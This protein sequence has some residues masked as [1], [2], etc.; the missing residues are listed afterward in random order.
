MSNYPN[1]YYRLFPSLYFFAPYLTFYGNQGKKEWERQCQCHLFSSCAKLM[2]LYYDE[3][4]H[5]VICQRDLGHLINFNCTETFAKTFQVAVTDAVVMFI[6]TT[7][8][9]T[10]GTGS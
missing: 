3:K 8:Y 4:R 5:S 2:G 6:Q 10:S 1:G 9:I 7:F